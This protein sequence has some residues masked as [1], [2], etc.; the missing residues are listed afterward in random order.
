MFCFAI[1]IIVGLNLVVCK[2]Y[3]E[4]KHFISSSVIRTTQLQI[5]LELTKNN[6][7]IKDIIHFFCFFFQDVLKQE[8]SSFQ[9]VSENHF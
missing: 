3:D 6:N 4:K 5:L 2:S 9:Y 7:I 8:K 1:L